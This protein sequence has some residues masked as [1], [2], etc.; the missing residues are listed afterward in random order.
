VQKSPF[1]EHQFRRYLHLARAAVTERISSGEIGRARDHSECRAVDRHVRQT[2]VGMVEDVE[3]LW[4]KLQAEGSLIAVD[5][6]TKK[7]A[8]LDRGPM[9]LL[10]SAL[11]KVPERAG[12]KAAVLNQASARFGPLFGSPTVRDYLGDGESR[13]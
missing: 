6:I 1:L 5:F 7:S 11:P 4:A 9:I 12:T 8:V 13:G 10:R 3:K 2:E